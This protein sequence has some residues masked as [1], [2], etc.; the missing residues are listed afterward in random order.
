VLGL[1][2]PDGF[3]FLTIARPDDL[4]VLEIARR[5]LALH[6]AEAGD[7]RTVSLA[8]DG[9]SEGVL[10]VRLPPQAIEEDAYYEGKRARVRALKRDWPRLG[11]KWLEREGCDARKDPRKG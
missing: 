6:V 9:S 3:A 4:V 5:D 1:P 7:E 11:R 8:T 2:R 10:V